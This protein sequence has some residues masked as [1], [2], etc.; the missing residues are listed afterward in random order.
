MQARRMPAFSNSQPPHP[1]LLKY[2]GSPVLDIKPYVPFCDSVPSARAPEWVASEAREEP[3]KICR[4]EFAPGSLEQVQTAYSRRPSPLR[5][6]PLYASFEDFRAF[7]EQA[8]SR[9]IRSVHQRLRV[10]A[11]EKPLPSF[12]RRPGEEGGLGARLGDEE[13]EGFGRG[14]E[15]ESGRYRLVVEGVDVGY[16][17]TE[18]RVVM[19]RGA[20]A[21]RKGGEGE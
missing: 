9:D 10:V 13:D 14:G 18:D 12:K 11:F 2:P 5:K 7:L 3:L 6:H 1:S 15:G 20:R 4:V 21:G 8:L 19:V 16:D 17:I